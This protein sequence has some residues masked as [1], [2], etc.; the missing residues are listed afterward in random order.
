MSTA[1]TVSPLT[2]VHASHL[3]QPRKS[4]EVVNT[5]VTRL[6]SKG[7]RP[8]V[9][10][11]VPTLTLART[12]QTVLVARS[13]R[14]AVQQTTSTVISSEHDS[15]R[16]SKTSPLK[17]GTPDSQLHSSCE[18]G[19]YNQHPDT[20]DYR[21]NNTFT[22]NPVVPS[23]NDVPT[24]GSMPHQYALVSIDTPMEECD[25]S[26]V[27]VLAATQ[28]AE[29]AQCR[30]ASGT[31]DEIFTLSPIR[32]TMV[33]P[34]ASHDASQDQR[35]CVEGDNQTATALSQ[36]SGDGIH[37][38]TASPRVDQHLVAEPE[39]PSQSTGA[40]SPVECAVLRDTS[41][42]LDATLLLVVDD[43]TSTACSFADAEP[44][45]CDRDTPSPSPSISL[46]SADIL[47]DVVEE[48]P[49]TR[50][51]APVTS[52]AEAHTVLGTGEERQQLPVQ[53]EAAAG[54]GR[55]ASDV[56]AVEC[57]ADEHVCDAVC[58]EDVA[59]PSV[60]R[61][62]RRKRHNS[63]STGRPLSIVMET[64]SALA[65]TTSRPILEAIPEPAALGEVDEIAD[66]T[67]RDGDATYQLG[68]TDEAIKIARARTDAARV[69][70]L[71]DMDNETAYRLLQELEIAACLFDTEP[72]R[73]D[74]TP[75]DE[76]A[77]DNESDWSYEDELETSECCTTRR[78]SME[79]TAPCR[80]SLRNDTITAS[81]SHDRANLMV[82]IR[83]D[84]NM[85]YDDLAQT[86]DDSSEFEE[87]G[88]DGGEDPHMV[89]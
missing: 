62:E 44:S 87:E 45:R 5:K 38:H 77:G 16:S 27:L 70:Q 82:R 67:G 50:H 76:V 4:V 47:A 40:D 83:T 18:E 48:Q 36:P 64:P 30:T 54:P 56:F 59:V 24:E 29:D 78:V 71:G 52:P 19:F 63:G 80:H 22:N 17:D 43:Q 21:D 8:A 25:G 55:G 65:L 14:R 26:A 13:G 73:G 37:C 34:T 31:P 53:E 46:S 84:D 10:S 58:E 49:P 41:P 66:P 6:R 86:L 81:A 20:N 89:V 35:L 39:T 7:K 23:I 1:S 15:A 74:Y 28:R 9:A 42:A 11:A 79:V 32:D 75:W 61:P 33:E 2:S 68:G 12:P 57:L 72:A 3:L 69:L 51:G 85:S 88:G 60:A